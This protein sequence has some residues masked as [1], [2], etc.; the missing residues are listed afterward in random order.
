MTIRG[1]LGRV[2]VENQI[3]LNFEIFARSIVPIPS[4]RAG[5]LGAAVAAFVLAQKAHPTVTIEDI[6]GFWKK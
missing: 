3:F 1:C 5:Q 6:K 2:S 4:E